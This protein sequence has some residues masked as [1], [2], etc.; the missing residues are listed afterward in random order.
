MIDNNATQA[1][2]NS[3]RDA[4]ISALPPNLPSDTRNSIVSSYEETSMAI[5]NAIKTFVLSATIEVDVPTSKFDNMIR[6]FMTGSEEYPVMG[7]NGELIGRG[8]LEGQLLSSIVTPNQQTS[9]KL[10]GVIR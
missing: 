8:I 2:S 10:D 6:T 4:F 3:I 7:N 5:A 1:L 9:I